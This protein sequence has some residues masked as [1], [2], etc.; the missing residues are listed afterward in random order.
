LAPFNALWEQGRATAPLFILIGGAAGV[1]KSTL[2]QQLAREIPHLSTVSTSVLRAAT[3]VF[4][5]IETNSALHR[6]TFDLESAGE[7]LEQARPITQVVNR[8]IQFAGSEHQH[9]LIEGS[10]LIP[11]EYPPVP[12]VLLVEV[13]LKVSDVARHAAMMGGPTHNR[14]LSTTQ[15]RNCRLLHDFILGR[16]AACGRPTFEYTDAF[17]GTLSLIDRAVAEV[18]DSPG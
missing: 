14:T 8:L 10:N 1:G 9:W 4:V 18:I 15:V 17:R 16:A 11:G 12:G 13:Y 3:R 6:H 7:L 2:A 5:P